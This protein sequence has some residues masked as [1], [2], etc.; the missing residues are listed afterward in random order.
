MEI[1]TE[2]TGNVMSVALA[3]RL[4]AGSSN[5]TEAQLLGLIEAGERNLVVDLADLSYITS[6]GLAVLLWVAKRLK[7]VDG[8][9]VVCALQPTVQQVYEIAGFATIIPVFGTRR[10]AI[11]DLS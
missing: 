4:D 7:S 9:I 11:A 2:K 3:G 10:E 8:R 5:T 1:H 6:M